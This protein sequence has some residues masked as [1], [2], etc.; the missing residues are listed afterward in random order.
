[1]RLVR[2][3]HITH[4]CT[5]APAPDLDNVQDVDHSDPQDLDGLG[6]R[7]FSVERDDPADNNAGDAIDVAEEPD[8]DSRLRRMAQAG[9]PLDFNISCCR[10]FCVHA[11]IPIL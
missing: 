10:V 2:P 8:R 4:G 3:Q 1:M 5:C 11:H 9:I 7:E 6:V